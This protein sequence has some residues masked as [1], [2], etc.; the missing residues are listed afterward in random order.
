MSMKNTTASRILGVI[1][2]HFLA[3]TLVFA[4]LTAASVHFASKLT[5]E[6][7]FEALLPRSFP[8]VMALDEITE[9]FGG[10]GYLVLDVESDDLDKAKEFCAAL[11]SRLEKLPEVRYVS[12]RQPR[13]YFEDRKLLYL[14]LG[15][16]REIRRRIAKKITF[17][18]QRANPLFIDLLDEKYELDFSD[19]EKKY[20]GEEIFRDYYVSADGRELILLVKPS[21]L[22]GDLEFSRRLI[23]VARA[24]IEETKPASYH[25]SIK[26]SFTGR[27]QKQLDLNAQLKGDLKY[28]IIG[29]IVLASLLLAIYF[30]QLRPL[31]LISLPLAVSLSMTFA[32]AYLLIGYVNIIS[33]FL[34]SILM[35]VGLDY[36]I[37]FY[38]RYSE[39]RIKGA[40]PA[41][42]VKRTGSH[43]GRSIIIAGFTTALVFLTLTAAEFKG[44]SQFGL[45]AGIGVLLNILTFLTLFPSLILLTEKLRAARYTEAFSMRLKRGRSALYI[46]ALVTCALF[47]VFSLHRLDKVG[48]E[49][50]FSKIQGSNIPSFALDEKVNTIIGASLTPDLA[51][52]NDLGEAGAVSDLIDEKMKDP[53]T[54]IAG[55][56]SLRT[57]IPEDQDKKLA[58]MREVKALLD[59]NAL[60]ALEGEQRRR[61]EDAKKLLAPGRVALANLPQEILRMFMGAGGRQAVLIF[62]KIDL[63]DAELVRRSSDEIRDL[64]IPG[65]RTVHS[66]SESIIFS[67]ILNMIE[68]DGRTVILLAF[69]VTALPLLIAYRGFKAAFFILVPLAAGASWIFGAMTLLGMKFNF[70]NVVIL[71]LIFG[72]GVDYGEYIYNRYLE[73]GPGSI[74]FVML[75][76]GPAVGMSA[77][78]TM[79]GFGTLLF[80]DH[81][82]LNTI[83]Q[84]AVLG[85]VCVLLSAATL[86]PAMVTF[87]ERLG[88]RKK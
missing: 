79:M 5:F 11:V 36:G 86:L 87:A 49:Y 19:I 3:I 40:S 22:A 66:C 52:V 71:P 69:A 30:R 74:S 82:G 1:S 59:D 77:L 61:L 65:G 68:K 43:T 35:G 20:E 42:A 10:T 9:E 29:S 46:P 73:A 80:A 33:A 67:D 24:A 55:S 76:T 4:A 26:V 57:F 62:P 28:T 37:V 63:G 25:P 21:G 15:D 44:F 7:S 41:E 2:R 58:V 17:E 51:L 31:F 64:P 12:W 81:N 83:G 75:H 38:S 8:S 39:E 78:T 32:L 53:D 45:I 14:D 34:I 16:L 72:L 23:K 54:T 88:R 48:F 85:I 56:A 6:S 84:V 13:Q 47:T 18:K 70:F 50:N 27:Y 60:N